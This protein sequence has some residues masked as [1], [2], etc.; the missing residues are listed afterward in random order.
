[1]IH[2]SDIFFIWMNVV[3]S[4]RCYLFSKD[5]FLLKI[6]RVENIVFILNKFTHSFQWYWPGLYCIDYLWLIYSLWF[7]KLFMSHY[8]SLYRFH[9]ILSK[10]K[11]FLDISWLYIYSFYRLNDNNVESMPSLIA[12]S[13]YLSNFNVNLFRKQSLILSCWRSLINFSGLMNLVFIRC[14]DL[15]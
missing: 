8:L 15:V 5:L 4:V 2:S 10:G 6:K 9:C 7:L 14:W 3:V 12:L 13:S 1:M 11:R